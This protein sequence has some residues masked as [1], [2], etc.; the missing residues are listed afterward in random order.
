MPSMH[1]CAGIR[2]SRHTASSLRWALVGA[3]VCLTP[4]LVSADIIRIH[5]KEEL[6]GR[7][8]QR[9]ADQ[10]VVEFEF[11]TMTFAPGE[12]EVLPDP[13]PASAAPNLAAT[14]ASPPPFL[15]PS[16][17]PTVPE[18]APTETASAAGTVSLED[19]IKAVVFIAV[20]KTDGTVAGGSGMLIN[21]HGTLL[22]N[23]HVIKDAKEIQ[24]L[25]PWKQ[26][27]GSKELK[28]YRGSV[29]K[30]HKNYDLA[31]VDTHMEMPYYV[32]FAAED[33]LTVGSE[34]RAIGNPSGLAATVSRGI[35]SAVR[36]NEEMRVPYDAQA[37][38][39][40]ESMNEREFNAMTWVQTDAAINPGNSGGPLLNAQNEVIGINSFIVSSSGTSAGLGFAL[41]VK[42]LRKFAA[43]Q[44]PPD[45]EKAVQASSAR[46]PSRAQTE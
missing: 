20:M 18:P 36:T 37:L 44:L 3:A 46:K 34:V 11:G 9:S 1:R 16:A 43:G 19:A 24:V 45:H 38:N 21:R 30:Q 10:V 42:H 22:T 28:T 7:V 41:H 31:L 17:P 29:I 26:R 8:L 5:G 32:R 4:A 15:S 40:Y 27:K 14:P 33:A 2:E 35:I 13:A 25:L 12:I 39:A 23:H 6:K